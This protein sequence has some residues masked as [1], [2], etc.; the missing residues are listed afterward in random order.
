MAFMWFG[1]PHCNTYQLGKLKL[2]GK[3][4]QWPRVGLPGYP[5][6]TS[7]PLGCKQKCEVIAYSVNLYQRVNLQTKLAELFKRPEMQNGKA[8]NRVFYT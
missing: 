5:V 3:T 2:Q 7:R 8:L 6:G 4:A 1:R